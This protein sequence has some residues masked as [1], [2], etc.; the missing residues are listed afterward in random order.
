[1]SDPV[2]LEPHTFVI[3][4]RPDDAPELPQAELD[5]LQ[6]GHLAHLSDLRDRGILLAAGPLADQPDESLRGFCIYAT[7]RAETQ[8]LADAD[9]SVRAGRLVADVMTWRTL[10]G[11]LVLGREDR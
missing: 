6:Q 9:P 2:H 5:L 10:P 3:L 7:D 4:R 1:M 8:R 11:E